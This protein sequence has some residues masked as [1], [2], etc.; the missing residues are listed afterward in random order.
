MACKLQLE[1]GGIRLT[2]CLKEALEHVN[3]RQVDS[4]VYLPGAAGCIHLQLLKKCLVS[5]LFGVN[6]AW[7]LQNCKEFLEAPLRDIHAAGVAKNAF[8]HL[9]SVPGPTGEESHFATDRPVIFQ[10]RAVKLRGFS[11]RFGRNQTLCWKHVAGYF[12]WTSHHNP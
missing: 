4:K 10:G 6:S 1:V 11:T 8:L 9:P 3:H 2:G 5:K 12:W 7:Y